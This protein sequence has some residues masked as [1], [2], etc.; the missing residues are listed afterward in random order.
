MEGGSVN[1]RNNFGVAA[2]VGGLLTGRGGGGGGD[3][4]G[5]APTPP[6]GG[7]CW[8]VVFAPDGSRLA[9]SCGYRKVVLLPWDKYNSCLHTQ[10]RPDPRD[11]QRGLQEIQ[12][13]DIDAGFP[14]TSLAFGT[15]VPESELHC[16]RK[17]WLRFDFTQDLIFATGHR[18]GRIRVWDPYTG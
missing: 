7:E 5:E 17:Y 9:W 13:I 2:V 8:R 1:E 4:G 6:P 3:G 12:K 14:V 10:D 11:I 16:K 18:N 15:G